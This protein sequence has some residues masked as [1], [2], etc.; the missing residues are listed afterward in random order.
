MAGWVIQTAEK[1]I[2]LIYDRLKEELGK[3]PVI[4]ADETP[5][6]NIRST[7]PLRTAMTRISQLQSAGR[8]QED[9]SHRYARVWERKEHQE[10]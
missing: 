4:H 6:T 2:S 8:M 5:V 1:Y 7:I 3:S 10:Q 9:H